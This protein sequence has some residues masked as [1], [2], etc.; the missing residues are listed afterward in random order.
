MSY[1]AAIHTTAAVTF[2]DHAKYSTAKLADV[3]D[4]YYYGV[5]CQSCMRSARISLVR[6]RAMLGEDYPLVRE[7]SRL[8]CR[9]CG[10]KQVTVTFLNP[11]QAVGSLS[12]LFQQESV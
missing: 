4:R 7:V 8:K 10:S 1:T 2:V 3:D 11:N 6:L 12:H 5:S 9:T